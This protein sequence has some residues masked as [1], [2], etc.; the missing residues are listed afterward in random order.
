[1]RANH[2]V[3]SLATGTTDVGFGVWPITQVQHWDQLRAFLEAARLGSFTA[4][5]R[6]IGTD[7]STIARRVH[8]LESRLGAKL[9]IR[10]AHGIKL[11]EPGTRVFQKTVK[12][13]ELI[14]SL[15][16][17]ASIDTGFFGAVRLGVTDGIGAYFLPRCLAKFHET[18]PGICL[19]VMC[20]ND[21]PDIVEMEADLAITFREPVASDLVVLG[22]K[23]S[24]FGLYASPDYIERR[25]VPKTVDDLKHHWLV[26]RTTF[27]PGTGWETW[28]ELVKDCKAVARTNSSVALGYMTRFGA[29]ISVQPIGI[30]N[31]EPGFVRI[32]IEGLRLEAHYWLVC[33]R[34]LKDIPRIRAVIDFLQAFFFGMS[35]P[36]PQA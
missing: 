12:I 31:M 2:S 35:K 1:M 27:P 8:A 33:R 14:K 15:N 13:E 32:E 20:T 34:E 17:D 36:P 18:Y 25:G 24:P 10:T 5:G 29:G 21:I 3:E 26:D 6:S 9:C 7:V 30:E 19:E 11:T 4:A 23:A 28:R 22:Q 16:I